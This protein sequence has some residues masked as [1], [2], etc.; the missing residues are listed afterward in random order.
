MTFTKPLILLHKYISHYITEILRRSD[1]I[2]LIYISI[3]C[4]D[5]GTN[6][7]PTLCN[8]THDKDRDFNK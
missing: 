6:I 3:G 8:I 1:G 4:K 2:F 7:N 5:N